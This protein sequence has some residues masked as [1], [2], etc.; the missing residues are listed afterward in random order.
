MKQSLIAKAIWGGVVVFLAFGSVLQAAGASITTSKPR[1]DVGEGMQIQGSGFTAGAQISIAVQR[2]D[3]II[4]NVSGTIANGSG[5]FQAIYTPPS[6]PGRYRITATDGVNVAMTAT[7]EADAIGYNK[8]VYNKNQTA[9]NDT[10]GGWTTGNAGGNYRENQWAYYQYQ[11][12]GIGTTIPDFD[13]E[14]N[15]YE[16]NVNAVFI[17]ALANFRVCVDCTEDS[18]LSGPKQ[19]M[20]LDSKPFPGTGTTNWK[21]AI[22]AISHINGEFDVPTST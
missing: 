3:K 21:S 7:T 4:D 5:A 13:V 20:L 10:T 19:G 12:T 15:H 9:Y 11:V 8:G 16:Q 2:P 1:Y 18:N 17:D 6:I 14:W 22:S